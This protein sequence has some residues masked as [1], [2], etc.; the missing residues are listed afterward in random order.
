MSSL[1]PSNRASQ[2]PGQVQRQT[3]PRGRPSPETGQAQRQAKFR[4]QAKSRRQ[5]KKFIGKSRSMPSLELRR[6][7]KPRW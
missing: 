3:K 1:E 7:A 6:K 5:V 2:E 4:R